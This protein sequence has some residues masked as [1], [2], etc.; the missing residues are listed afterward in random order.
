[1]FAGTL[2]K[3]GHAGPPLTGP[4]S[5]P[6][7]LTK[8]LALTVLPAAVLLAQAVPTTDP[9]KW[10]PGEVVFVATTLATLFGGT[11]T[12]SL[13]AIIKAFKSDAKAVT[14]TATA[15]RAETRAETNSTAISEQAQQIQQI[16]LAVPP[17][18]PGGGGA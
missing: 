1:M 9:C 16:S 17:P 18:G 13:I 3:T 5:S 8:I 10:T 14:A 7:F 6:M 11:I 15:V 2:G 12:A 4:G